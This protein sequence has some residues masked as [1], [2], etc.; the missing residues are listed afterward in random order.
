MSLQ[1]ITNITILGKLEYHV[2][3]EDDTL[4]ETVLAC[5][6]DYSFDFDADELSRE[7]LEPLPESSL[8]QSDLVVDADEFDALY[9]WFAS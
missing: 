4:T 5:T 7:L 6:Q 3:H 1:A 2:A 9:R 8:D